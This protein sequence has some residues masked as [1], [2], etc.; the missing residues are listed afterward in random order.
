M[1]C[2]KLS[3]PSRPDLSIVIP[4]F[5]EERR[6][7]LTLEI[8]ALFLKN[9]NFFEGKTVEVIVSSADCPDKTHE[10]VLEKQ[11]L[12]PSLQLLNTGPNR[13][14][15]YSV[16]QGMLQAAGKIIIFMDADLATPLRHLEKFYRACES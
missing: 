6:I 13:G 14:K 4:A 5:C 16:Q 7:G 11:S 2:P 12:F 9:D 8:L 10:I 15:G 1:T 3:P